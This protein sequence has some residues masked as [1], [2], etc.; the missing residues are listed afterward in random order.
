MRL[1]L[2]LHAVMAFN[3]KLLESLPICRDFKAGK[4]HRNTECRYVHLI[5]EN[6]EVNQGR[7]TVCR[8]AA[9]GRC[10]RI[11]CKYYHIPL[12]AI[13]ASRSLALNSALSAAVAANAFTNTAAGTVAA[14]PGTA[15]TSTSSLTN[16]TSNNPLP[17]QPPST[18]ASLT[19]SL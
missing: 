5:D 14:S 13:S 12:I 7:V 18:S 2:V 15:A 17:S 10:T 8:D 9:K 1:D 19:K 11:P 4:C 6:V 16:G 3:F